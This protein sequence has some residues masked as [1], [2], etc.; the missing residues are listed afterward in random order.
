MAGPLN[1]AGDHVVLV[2][3]DEPASL[4]A[5]RRALS[6]GYEVLTAGSAVEAL[7]VLA[8]RPVAL[9][10]A[11]QRMPGA[12]GTE[13]LAQTVEQ[14]PDLVRVML[15]GYAD[16]DVLQEAINVGGLYHCLTKPWKAHELRQVVQRGLERY[17]AERERSRLLHE[18]RAA[19]VR[20]QREVEQKSRLLAVTAHELGT[21]L[22][23][24]LNATDLALAAAPPVAARRWIQTA[25]RAG[26]W[27]ARG[28]SQMTA[29]ARLSEPKLR[30]RCRPV[31]LSPLLAELIHELQQ[32]AAHRHLRITFGSAST[33]PAL[34]VDERWM[35]R[36]LW[37]LLTNAVRFTP[38]GGSVHVD[39]RNEGGQVAVAVRDSGIGIAAAHIEEVFEPFSAAAGDLSLH[40]SGV[41]EFGSRGIGLGLAIARQVAMAHGGTVGVCSAPGRGS[42]F[43][44]RVPTRPAP[45][46]D[47]RAS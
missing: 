17:A 44:I 4:R 20:V 25:Q 30:L 1:T 8:A 18:L 43:T 15:T 27:L 9:V 26:R 19:Y 33:L 3:D 2:V 23:I 40:G 29:V 39:V 21:P 34:M 32:L 14:Y 11:D 16:V 6:D 38:D 45:L 28:V 31:D 41:L 35:R 7:A 24:L 12:L 46:A 47:Q 22:H 5:V 42:C 13:F 10:I 37:N 36:A